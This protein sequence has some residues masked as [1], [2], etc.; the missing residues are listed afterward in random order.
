[1]KKR[2]FLFGIL[3]LIITSFI[4]CGNE[5]TPQDRFQAF[6]KSWGNQDFAGMY[7]LTSQSTQQ[8]IKKE[9]FVKRYQTIYGE[10]GIEVSQLDVKF[11]TPKEEVKPNEKGE[12]I[13]PYSVKMNT[14]AGPYEFTGKAKLVKEK[15]EKEENW[16]VVWEPSMILAGMKEGD[17]VGARILPAAR[18]QILD[19]NGAGL[20]VNDS[21]IS[22]GVIPDKLGTDVAIKEKIAQLLGISIDQINKS[23]EEPWVKPNLFVPIKI[24]A[25]D[26]KAKLDQ[27]TKLPGVSSQEVPVRYYPYKEI[28]AHLIG[29]V[30]NI[31]AEELQSLKDKGYSQSDLVGKSG[32]EK[33]FEEKLRGKNGGEIFIIDGKTNAHKVIAKLDPIDGE[34]IQLTIDINLQKEIYGQFQKDSGTAVAIHPKTGEVLALVNSPS[35]NPNDF[36]LGIS[37]KQWKALNEDPKK[38]LINRFAQTYTPG[39]AFKPITAAIGLKTGVIQPDQTRDIKGLSW[40]KD[41]SWGNYFIKRVT[42][43]EKPVNLKDALIYSDNI[44]F[45]QTALDIGEDRF[46]IEAKNFGFLESLPFPFPI[47]RSKLVAKDNF[48]N[49]IQLADTGYGQGE[50]MMN[51]LHLAIAYTPFLNNGDLLKPTLI[52]GENDSKIWKDNLFTTE[53]ANTIFQDLIQ[54]VE[55]PKGTAYQPRVSGIKIAGKTGTAEIKGKQGETGIE[56]GWF[57]AVNTDNPRLMIVM[58]IEDVQNRGGSHYV[59]SKV[60]NIFQH[61]ELYPKE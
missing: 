1:M 47:T 3:F 20:A 30:G 17:R 59:V 35:F 50:V 25:K 32:L 41:E 54:V 55:N 27:L 14:L 13:F 6:I 28:I 33:I 15:R 24:I 5:T 61:K 22:I 4:G 56:N 39:S 8:K 2:L 18:G 57:I 12:I 37:Q 11:Q 21:A 43:P 7:D 34:N 16:Y 29:Y 60:K 45:A 31:T 38:P 40:Q 19:R 42:D 10:Q 51:P 44:Y 53:A 58:M 26:Q 23:L 52:K 36:V 9:E 49:E 46:L 48:Q